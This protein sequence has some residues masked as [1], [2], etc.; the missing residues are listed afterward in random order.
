MRDAL[1]DSGFLTEDNIRPVDG[2]LR[3]VE[4]RFFLYDPAGDAAEKGVAAKLLKQVPPQ[5]R[6]T[7]NPFDAGATWREKMAES[8]VAGTVL[9]LS[10]PS[11]DIGVRE[12]VDAAALLK[13][14]WII[15]VTDTPEAREILCHVAPTF[16]LAGE[17]DRVFATS[18]AAADPTQVRW[19]TTKAPATPA[20]ATVSKCVVVGKAG[21]ERYVLGIVLEPDVVDAQNDTYS[22]DEVRRAEQVFMEQYRHTGLMHREKVDDVVKILESYLAPV[23]FDLSG[24]A[25]KKGTWLMAVHVLDD[26]LWKQVKAGG[27]TGFSIGGSAVRT[28]TKTN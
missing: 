5:A 16:K 15:D 28:P 17:P 3:K 12:L 20:A 23:D 14:D 7:C 21:E 26:E 11:E 10:P 24:T 19:V 22:A 2:E 13:A 6:V 8:D 25:V 18:F 4:V 27:L 9:L 1:V